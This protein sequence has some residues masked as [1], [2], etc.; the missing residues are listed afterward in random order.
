MHTRTRSKAPIVEASEVDE[1]EESYDEYDDV[2]PPLKLRMLMK[3][4]DEKMPETDPEVAR[5]IKKHKKH[6]MEMVVKRLNEHIE[7]IDAKWRSATDL[8]LYLAFR[9]KGADTE[10]LLTALEDPGF[11]KAIR[12][13]ANEIVDAYNSRHGFRRVTKVVQ[14]KE[15]KSKDEAITK[16]KQCATREAVRE[17]TP[18]R[19]DATKWVG[20]RPEEISEEVWSSWSVAHRDSYL[21]RKVNPNTY[22]YRNLPPG[23]TPRHGAWTAQEQELFM[24]RLAE[25]RKKGILEGKWGLFSKK[26]PGRVGYQCSNFYRKLIRDGVIQDPSYQLDDEGC[27]RYKN[28]TPYHKGSF[29]KEG[30]TDNPQQP[31]KRE[32]QLS[33]YE[34]LAQDNPLKGRIDFITGEEIRVPAISPDG[35]VLD[36]HTW[37]KILMDTHEDPFTR[38]PINKRQLVVL[39]SANIEEYRDKIKNI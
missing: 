29:R 30:K 37:M 8:E 22:L 9:N 28:R 27:L 19:A 36:Y 12:A 38:H 3:Y 1:E 7:E 32:K 11:K 33:K 20:Q 35:N 25:M 17:P 23:E 24:Q 6:M 18:K 21:K 15:R 16:I 13:E 5:T 31:K 39:T 4:F 34:S 26:I 14:S 10:E 2:R